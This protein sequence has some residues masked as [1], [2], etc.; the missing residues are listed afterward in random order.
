ML[1]FRLIARLDIKPPNLVK[2]IHLDGVKRLDVAPNDAA[3]RYDEA[4][5]DELI[6][7]DIVASLYQR[8]GLRGMLAEATNEI[9]TPVA[10]GGGVSS[11]ADANALLRAGADKVVVNTAATKRPE[12][13]A[14]LARKFGSQAVVLQLDVKRRNGSWE[15]MCDGGRQR[16]GKEAVSWAS[17]AADLG[18]GEILV[19]SIDC[20]GCGRGIDTALCGQVVSAVGCPVV[21]GGGV[22]SAEHVVDAWKAGASGVAMAGALHYGKVSLDEM[23]GALD[24]AGAKVR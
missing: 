5:I 22:G 23:R 4:G 16:T 17:E 9:F 8:N 6:Y 14:D 13:I 7:L 11:V 19:T 21:V 3:R 12:L 2:T 10:A 1:A 20:E 24:K 18:A 15:A